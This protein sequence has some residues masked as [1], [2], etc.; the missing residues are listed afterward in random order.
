[1]PAIRIRSPQE[2]WSG[3]IFGFFGACGLWFGRDLRIGSPEAMGPGFLPWMLSIILLGFAAILFWRS[4]A[5]EGP[6][7]ERPGLRS[8]FFVL[9]AIVAFGLTIERLGLVIATIL[10]VGLASLAARD[11]RWK[12]A[13]ALSLGMAVFAVVVFIY[14]LNQYL[15]IWPRWQ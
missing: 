5:I 10:C 9:F 1:M 12:E 2:F 6:K 4:I 11:M 7:V 15:D 13:I 14:G 8:N 3:S